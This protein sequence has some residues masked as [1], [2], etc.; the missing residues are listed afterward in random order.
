MRGNVANWC[1][2][3]FSHNHHGLISISFEIPASAYCH[4]WHTINK[5]Q[6]ITP[7]MR[8]LVFIICIAINL[9]NIRAQNPQSKW[10]RYSTP[11]EA[12]FSSEKSKKFK[13][14][15]CVIF[16]IF[17]PTKNYWMFIFNSDIVL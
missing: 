8:L 14:L 4:R 5:S 13:L 10:M 2:C 11:E 16:Y 12:G 7:I 9:I 3:T 17:A 15:C 1:L 6:Y